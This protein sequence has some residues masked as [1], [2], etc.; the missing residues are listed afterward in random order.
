MLNAG[1]GT[2]GGVDVT[3]GAVVLGVV[4]D[5]VASLLLDVT[6][7]VVFAMILVVDCGDTLGVVDMVLDVGGMAGTV[8]SSVQRLVP[9]VIEAPFG[10]TNTVQEGSLQHTPL[11]PQ[12]PHVRPRAQAAPA[13]SLQQSTA[14]S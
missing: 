6:T 3:A 11:S 2:D 10:F 4:L 5:V 13:L 14:P 7:G 9:A 8:P 12:K 1:A